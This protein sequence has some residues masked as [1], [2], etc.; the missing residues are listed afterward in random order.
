MTDDQKPRKKDK[1]KGP[2]LMRRDQVDTGTTDQRL[3]DSRGPSDWVH[4]DPWRV[5]ADH[6]PSSSRASASSPSSAR[7]SASS[8]PPARP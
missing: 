5:H 2:V 8:A 7:P 1:R 4:T 6:S 3:L